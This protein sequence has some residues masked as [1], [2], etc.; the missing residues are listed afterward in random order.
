M[1]TEGE[2]APCFVANVVLS[3]PW[4]IILGSGVNTGMAGKGKK[5]TL[6]SGIKVS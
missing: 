4:G 5:I 6:H 3:A 1:M 2:G